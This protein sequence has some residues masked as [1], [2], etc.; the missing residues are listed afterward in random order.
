MGYLKASGLDSGRQYSTRL[1]RPPRTRQTYLLPWGILG[2]AVEHYSVTAGRTMLH[3]PGD[4]ECEYCE[5][6]AAHRTI[7][8]AL[9]TIADVE[10]VRMSVLVFSLSASRLAEE[11][12]D[13]SRPIRITT[14][15]TGDSRWSQLVLPECR[16]IAGIARFDRT[17]LQ[18]CDFAIKILAHHMAKGRS[19]K[20][21]VDFGA[22][23]PFVELPKTV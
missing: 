4:G 20:Q 21:L 17:R 6:V 16:N 5:P 15:R 11:M 3:I 14:K 18:A 10:R 7:T 9:G 19:V 1:V 2:G 23:V 13:L 8:F 12:T 22:I